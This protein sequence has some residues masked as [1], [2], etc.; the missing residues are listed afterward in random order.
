MN[1]SPVSRRQLLL[2]T[3]LCALAL[4]A[5][6]CLNAAP[7]ANTVSQAWANPIMGPP[8]AYLE[9]GGIALASSGD[10]FV[11]AH[12]SA[13]HVPYDLIV[14]R[15][16]ANGNLVWERRYE[17]SDHRTTAEYASGIAVAG[18]N[19]YVISHAS[20]TNGDYD[21]LTLKYRDNG[22]LEWVRRFGG[23]EQ[24]SDGP[25]SVAADS[26]GNVLVA[27]DVYSTNGNYD[28]VVLK[29][30]PAGNLLWNHAYNAS[31]GSSDRVVGMKVDA[32]GN[33]HVVGSTA[34]GGDQY[35]AVTLRIS[36]DG[37]LLW[38]TRERSTAR[39]GFQITGMDIDADGNTVVAG[40][41][42]PYAFAWKYDAN[43]NRQW[44][45]RYRAE[46]P[47]SMQAARVR[48]DGAGKVLLGANLYGSGFN[49]AVVMKYSPNGEQLWTARVSE[50]WSASHIHSFTA[51]AD[52]NTYL[53]TAPFN[54]IITTKIGPGGHQLWSATQFANTIYD[55]ARFLEVDAAGNVIVSGR[56]VFGVQSVISLVKY[57]QAFVPGKPLATIT[58][59]LHVV[60]PGTN[61]LFTAVTTGTG[62]FTYQWRRAGRALEGA[63]N[64][65]LALP[66][67]QFV[68][69]GDY[70]VIVSNAIGS[71]IS[72][73][74]RLSVRMPP[75]VTID[76]TNQVAHLGT[77]AGFIAVVTGNDFIDYQW[78]HNGTNIP[79]ATN[80]LLYLEQLSGADGGAYDLVASSIGGT[81]T[82]SASGL[83][84]S[85]AVRQLDTSTHP[86]YSIGWN[87]HPRLHVFPDGHS[88]VVA[89]ARHPSY[90]TTITIRKVGP[91][92]TELWAREF[93]T[94]GFTNGQPGALGTD[95]A[96]NIYVAGVSLQ[97]YV[98]LA[99]CLLKYSPAGNLLW[100]RFLTGSNF[101]SVWIASLAIE[102]SGRSTLAFMGF[103]RMTV[104]RHSADGDALWSFDEPSNEADNLQA[105][106]DA[107]GNTYV[108]TTLRS[109]NAIRLQKLDPAGTLIWER[110]ASDAE[111]QY[112][113]QIA[114]DSQSNPIVIG[115]AYVSD[116]L[117]AT[118]FVAKY[119]PAG[120]RLWLTL[121]G[122]EEIRSVQAIA[123]TPDDEIVIATLSDDDYYPEQS[124]I[125]RLAADG[126][127]LHRTPELEILVYGPRQL[128]L[129]SFGN[130]Y[131]TGTGWR[132]AT[133]GD[134]V[135][136]KYDKQGQ[137]L[138]TAYHSSPSLAWEFGITLGLDARGDVRVLA[139]GGILPDS[140]YGLSLLHYEQRDPAGAFR[141]QIIRDNGGTFHLATPVTD[142]FRIE[143]STDLESWTTLSNAATQQLLQPG[144]NSFSTTPHRFYRLIF[145]EQQ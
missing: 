99:A 20:N 87:D 88:V 115:P 50:G 84:I 120:D 145:S 95:A 30:D 106:V 40:T 7:V 19:I 133:G 91:A 83:R 71:S 49:D 78:R 127:V 105:A 86:A 6:P 66:D 2:A 38:A 136:A 14:R 65:A 51:D 103:N 101:N 81:I 42:S 63:T 102:P 76:P 62:P 75:Q 135:T 27:G 32:A 94:P 10:I 74:A 114:I 37:A 119:S 140:S 43:G 3:L 79:G 124:G 18:S 4:T 144:V 98:P 109:T 22:D 96:G 128:A 64:A 53:A 132:P 117:R 36:A 33:A 58:P 23:V 82:T 5:A 126:R 97:P 31:P 28:I 112:F 70:S 138:W 47:A 45:V 118:M 29:Y 92:G 54:R 56:S 48:F 125:T 77:E 107:G 111:Y 69:R 24:Y 139:N 72:P 34:N 122:G 110:R 142:P 90:G 59:S 35:G 73:E 25:V 68:H 134:V 44:I 104:V 93:G 55:Y 39:W 131:L 108:G 116:P 12:E 80:E 100:S 52:G 13:P 141:A 89:N 57:S 11:A 41:E 46:E 85:G 61:I 15:H 67:V 26:A 143:A 1:F 113:S 137:R 8:S 123:I 60:D 17:P 16:D 129:D 130:A 9:V 121:T 21:I